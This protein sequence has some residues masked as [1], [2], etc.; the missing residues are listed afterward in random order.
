MIFGCLVIFK[1]LIFEK[2]F[3]EYYQLIECEAKIKLDRL[4]PKL[5][6]TQMVYIPEEFFENKRLKRKNS[7]LQESMQNNQYAKSK[8]SM[9]SALLQIVFGILR[10][11]VLFI[12]LNSKYP[13][14]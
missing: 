7:G 11:K 14:L 12:F 3:Q 6:D 4:D 8:I 1:R 2:L 5:F 9:L 10:F 13:S